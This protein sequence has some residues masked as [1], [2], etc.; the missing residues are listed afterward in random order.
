MVLVALHFILLPC[1]VASVVLTWLYQPLY[2]ALLFTISFANLMFTRAEC[3]LTNLE[4]KIRKRL[5]LPKIRG[6][7]ARYIFMRTEPPV[8]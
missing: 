5:G 1:V 3:V 2:V 4:N 7:V 6:F 8:G